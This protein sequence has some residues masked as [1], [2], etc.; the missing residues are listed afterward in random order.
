M[1]LTI[2]TRRPNYV[3]SIE[4]MPGIS[5]PALWKKKSGASSM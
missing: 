5:I 4:T 3:L 2:T 1:D